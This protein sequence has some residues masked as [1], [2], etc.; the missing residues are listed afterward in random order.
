[1][2]APKERARVEVRLSPPRTTHTCVIPLH[3]A[4]IR[5]SHCSKSIDSYA[6]PL[7]VVVFSLSQYDYSPQYPNSDELTLK[8]GDIVEIVSRENETDGWVTGS[9]NGRLGVFPG[10]YV[11]TPPPAGAA[12]PPPPP[13]PKQAVVSALPVVSSENVKITLGG[14]SPPPPPP[15]QQQQSP[16]SP[17]GSTAQGIPM[18]SSTS[19]GLSVSSSTNAASPVGSNVRLGGNDN[20]RRR[21]TLIGLY[22][23][24][25]AMMSGSFYCLTGLGLLLWG[26]WGF[27]PSPIYDDH[28][29]PPAFDILD[30]CV[31]FF[32]FFCGFGIL[33]YE[34]RY[35]KARGGVSRVPW[36]GILYVLAGVPGCFALPTAIGAGTLFVSAIPNFYSSYLGEFYRPPLPPR[37]PAA[38]KAGEDVME[39]FSR[40]SR[41]LALFGGRNPD[42]QV[43]R[44]VFLVAYIAA[45]VIVGAFN[46]K[47][48][49]DAIQTIKDF[50]DDNQRNPKIPPV[51]DKQY[52]TYWVCV[53]KFFGGM[54]NL[55]Y[56]II[57]IPVA[58][59]VIRWFVDN[60]RTRTWYSYII[61]GILWFFPVDDAIKLHK[62][63]AWTAFAAAIGH[64]VA[65]LF[66]Y[67]QKSQLVW[68]TF[69]P[70]IWVTGIL[71][72]LIIFTVY[73]ATH[74]NVKR[75]HFEIFWITHMLYV[76]LFVLT[77]IH[78]KNMIGPNY[79]KFFIGPGVIYLGERI[80]REVATRK[81]V[82]VISATFMS[83]SVLSLVVAKSGALAKY[84]EG[85]YAYI[86]C[87]AI[88]G[89]QWHPFTISS[90]P[91]EDCV[92][93][94][95][96]V[97]VRVSERH[98]QN[99]LCD[100]ILIVFVSL[101]IY[102]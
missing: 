45:N 23:H 80:Y 90:A 56:S 5:S 38:G 68:D 19:S 24:Y 62:L 94:H 25:S 2:S 78:G 47:N 65:H 48:A 52:M 76:P 85:Q 86:C 11:K 15:F 41:C 30:A 8:V 64:T 60:S 27:S 34:I 49:Y 37:K 26:A 39:G 84:T 93:F 72:V 69:G 88:S 20:V 91:Q 97:Q 81:P 6:S 98:T 92:S 100:Y 79:W 18:S 43:S 10:N 36:R 9:I 12:P 44:I 13:M 28:A 61:R 1:M 102:F 66:N 82:N 87:P 50:N 17:V 35:G 46:A 4:L 57:L 67:V 73:P 63:I 22:A 77:L 99:S 101:D 14:A 31:G 59:S 58:H 71:L 95:I 75:G 55:N 16:K 29:S 53:A 7:L 32:A 40:G 21:Q 70:G 89:L 83:N 3:P 96:R 51:A 42:K 54:M 33:L 74:V